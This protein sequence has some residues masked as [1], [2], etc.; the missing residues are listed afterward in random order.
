YLMPQ[1]V[2]PSFPGTLLE[3]TCRSAVAHQIAYA[4]SKRVPWGISESGYNM[5]DAAQNYQYRAFGVPGLGLQRGLAQELVIAPYASALALTVLPRDAGRNLRR[6]ADNGWLTPLGFYE[7]IDYTSERVTPGE[8]STVVRSFMAHHHGMTL[9]AIAH[10][11]LDRPMQKRFA[12]DPELKATM[13][14]LQ[15]RTPRSAINWSN[16]PAMVDVRSVHDVPQTAVRVFSN[17]DT[18]RPALQLL[19]NGRYHVMVTS[20]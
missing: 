7:A 20:S 11:V 2:M 6:L 13:L 16:D 19:T 15:E 9:L 3:E 18:R 4:R 10:A 5:T 12:A 8:T 17:A 14:L 1:L